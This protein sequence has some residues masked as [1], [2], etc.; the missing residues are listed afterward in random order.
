MFDAVNLM[1]AST[2]QVAKELGFRN[3]SDCIGILSSLAE[4]AAANGILCAGVVVQTRYSIAFVLTPVGRFALF[5]SHSH[6][7]KGALVACTS[8]GFQWKAIP[9]I[10][11]EAVGEL[12]DSHVCLM[13][14]S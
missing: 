5:D 12:R 8:D 13:N 6:G 9:E 2:V 11:I 1:P 4:E 10:L 14:L 7:N 3:S